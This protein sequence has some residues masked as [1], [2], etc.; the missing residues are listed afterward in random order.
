MSKENSTTPGNAASS[1]DTG[2]GGSEPW[3]TLTLREAT[4]SGE[5]SVVDL[6]DALGGMLALDDAV[7]GVETRDPELFGAEVKVPDLVVYTTPPHLER[8]EAQAGKAARKMGLELLA[9]T[10]VR[11]DDDWRDSWK[12]Y[13][14]RTS[15]AD[16]RLL[17]RP[18]WLEREADDPA[19]ELVLDPGR[20]FGTGLHESTRLC[21]DALLREVEPTQGPTR[22]LDLGCGSGILGLALLCASDAVEQ[23]LFVDIDPE[24]VDTA[25]E[26]AELNSQL[27]R[28]RFQAGVLEDLEDEHFEF[29][30][31]NIRP[32]VLVPQ[33]QGIAARVKEGGDLLLSGI[34]IEEGAEV[35]AAYEGMGLEL[36][37]RH[38]LND[39]CA[40]HY[41]R[42]RP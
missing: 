4:P 36:F 19:R 18:S 39:W 38:E 31:A 21:L 35:A 6:L 34:L 17:L 5:A 26:N 7:G 37:A 11:T 14:Q 8:L 10:D 25:R 23:V 16:G 40:L 3:A 24:S 32:S 13:Y 33:A 22:V 9:A 12:Q 42:G 27:S 1:P 30:L 41:R 15:L 29:V 20:A 28:S 2:T